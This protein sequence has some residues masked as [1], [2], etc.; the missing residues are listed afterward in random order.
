[1]GKSGQR[2]GTITGPALKNEP[3]RVLGVGVAIASQWLG[4]F[5]GV[6]IV[7]VAKC[8]SYFLFFLIMRRGG[9]RVGRRH[10]AARLSIVRRLEA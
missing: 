3:D 7:F 5:E 9:D 8:R 1:M 10:G 2:S 6:A 4:D